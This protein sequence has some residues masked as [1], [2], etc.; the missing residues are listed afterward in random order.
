MNM[1]FK[2]KRFKFPLEVAKIA[3]NF[4]PKNK[5]LGARITA[6]GSFKGWN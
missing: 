3:R 2:I 5:I 1:G 4:W 6:N